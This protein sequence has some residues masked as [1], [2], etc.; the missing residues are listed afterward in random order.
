MNTISDFSLGLFLGATLLSAAALAEGPKVTV[1]KS[2]T[3]GCCTQW[4]SHLRKDG[5][6]VEPVDV[7]DLGG[8]K[9]M[10]GI[11]PEQASCHTAKIDGYVIEGHVPAGDIRRLL[12]E[13]PDA[14]GLAVPG[15]P[16]GSPGMDSPNPQHYQVL[17]IG[18]DGSTQVFAEH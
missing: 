16:M 7:N 13:R 5:F 3:C 4:I 8:V 11:Q 2:P 18:R 9:S 10:S 17:L 12:A 1:Y 14:G 6:E 15:M